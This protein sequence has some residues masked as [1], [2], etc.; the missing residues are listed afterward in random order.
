[1]KEE[2][3]SMVLND[4]V[5]KGKK[6]V[7]RLIAEGFSL[8]ETRWH[9]DRLP[10]LFWLGFVAG[11]VGN[12]QACD[13]AHEMAKG[14]EATVNRMRGNSKAVRAYA[15]SEHLAFT[16]AERS[17]I[18]RDHKDSNW[19][20]ALGPSLS[21]LSAIWPDFPAR[22]L[23]K[24]TRTTKKELRSLVDEIKALLGQSL[25]RHDKLSLNIQAIALA[26]EMRSG[27]LYFAKGLD[28]PDLNAVFDYPKTD[29]SQKAAGFI[30]TACSSMIMLQIE[31]LDIPRFKWQ[32][33]FWNTCYGLQRC[34]YE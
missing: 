5:R 23:A 33:L 19:L 27:H 9:V 24:S 14:I 21:A 6:L 15:M 18:V 22:Y 34:E 20:M 32:R 12:L 10:E 11:R 29:E 30:V 13:I 31:G 7:P 1:L 4:H 25:H 16:A 2:G 3:I 26:T 28:I 8:E 17:Q